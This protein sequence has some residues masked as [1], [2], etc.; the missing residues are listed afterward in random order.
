MPGGLEVV[1]N[2]CMVKRK[3]KKKEK[4]NWSFLFCFLILEILG[5]TIIIDFLKS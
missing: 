3:E 1:A 2:T 5:V 4:E